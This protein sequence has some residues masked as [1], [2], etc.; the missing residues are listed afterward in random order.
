MLEDARRY[1][2]PPDSIAS[3]EAQLAEL[4]NSPPFEVWGCNWQALEVFLALCNQWLPAPQGGFLGLNGQVLLSYLELI[5]ESRSLRRQLYSDVQM[6]ASG[7][8]SAWRKQVE[9][10]S[11]TEADDGDE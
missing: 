11:N 4:R 3:L 1:R 10:Q 7:A 8:I 9:Q 6:I 2:A 5:D